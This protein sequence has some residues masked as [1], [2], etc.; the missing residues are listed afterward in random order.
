MQITIKATNIELTSAIRDYV[1][2]RFNSVGKFVQKEGT[3]ALC[4]V[5]VGKVTNRH[6]KGEVFSAEARIHVRGKELYVSS[7]KEDLYVAID[8]VKDELIR[9]LQSTKEKKM[10]M[11]RRGGAKIKNMLKG[12]YDWGK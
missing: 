7:E 8:D 5:E 3:E 12:L 9:E 11:M 1:N 2:K 10:N 4:R 6:K